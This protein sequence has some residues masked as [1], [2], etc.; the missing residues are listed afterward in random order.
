MNAGRFE[1]TAIAHTTDNDRVYPK[2]NSASDRL[3]M[4]TTV[5]A[6]YSEPILSLRFSQMCLQSGALMPAAETEHTH[7]IVNLS[8]GARARGYFL[9]ALGLFP[10]CLIML[11]PLGIVKMSDTAE[12]GWAFARCPVL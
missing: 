3:G 1:L 6:I 7:W 9:I 8:H 2:S 10:V 11:V 5:S 12:P 4:P